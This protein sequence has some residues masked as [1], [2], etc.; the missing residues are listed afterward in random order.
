NTLLGEALYKQYFAAR[1]TPEGFVAF[2]KGLQ[3]KYILLPAESRLTPIMGGAGCDK[4]YGDDMAM[5]CR[6]N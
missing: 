4:V 3:A 2:G 1:A 5:V 6:I